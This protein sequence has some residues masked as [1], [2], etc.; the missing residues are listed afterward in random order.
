VSGPVVVLADRRGAEREPQLA[1]G[2]PTALGELMSSVLA[3][4]G[5]AGGAEAGLHLV[6]EAEITGLNREHMGVDGPTDVLSFP[7]DGAAAGDGGLV[8]D[9]VVCPAVAGSQA[10]GHAGTLLDE[11]RLLVVH[12]A[13]HLCGW[14][15]ADS[16]ARAAMWRRERELMGAL[17]VAPS[18]DPWGPG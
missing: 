7:V 4:E 16:T 18:A 3:A 6:D 11:C 15:H 5:V 13:L 8:G 10:V 9:V 12:G 2:E 17:G 14:D 1:P